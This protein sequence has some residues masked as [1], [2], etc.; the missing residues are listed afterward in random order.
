MAGIGEHVE[1]LDHRVEQAMDKWRGRRLPDRV[2]YAASA[3]GDHSLLWLIIG[4]A[5][6]LRSERDWKAAVRLG[7]CL[8][9]ESALVNGAV[10]SLVRRSRPPWDVHRPLPLRRPR[11]SSFPSGHATSGFMAASLLAEEARW[12]PAYYALAGVVASSR[13][14]VRTHHASDVLA[15]VAIGVALGSLARRL[16]PI[17]GR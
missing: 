9:A 12:G 13:V 5:R 16:F 11:T 10:K 6:G 8:G 14:Y 2:F 1:A 7:A 3:L 17:T 4:A 15:G